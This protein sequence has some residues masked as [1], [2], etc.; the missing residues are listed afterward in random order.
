MALKVARLA[1]VLRAHMAPL[2]SPPVP[3]WQASAS[4]YTVAPQAI[5]PLLLARLQFRLRTV[6]LS[7]VL[8][9]SCSLLIMRHALDAHRG[10]VSVYARFVF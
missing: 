5:S 1:P 3:R 8:I 10:R 7:R 4:F 2:R 6:L 9:L